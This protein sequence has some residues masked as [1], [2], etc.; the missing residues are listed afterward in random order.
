MNNPKKQHFVPEM[1]S[2]RFARPDGRFFFHDRRLDDN[3]IRPTTPANILHQRYLYSPTDGKGNRD[4]SLEL[5]YN[6][7][8]TAANLLFDRIEH[9]LEQGRTPVLLDT[10][11]GLLDLFIYE[12]WRRVP[13]MHQLVLAHEGFRSR[14]DTAISDYEQKYGPLSE[15]RKAEVVETLDERDVLKEIPGR[16]L[17]KSSGVILRAFQDKTLVIVEAPPDVEYIVGSYNVV[18]TSDGPTNLHD[19]SVEVWMAFTPRFAAVLQGRKNAVGRVLA[20]AD[21]IHAINSAV[22]TKSSI[23]ASKNI[24]LIEALRPGSKLQQSAKRA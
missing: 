15:S 20:G 18:K 12:Q 1:L 8:E 16:A 3:L 2:K 17:K 4:F 7:I 24:A 10:N 5:R 6:G 23:I 22:A 14:I 19:D 13:D 21:Q 9:V 11:R